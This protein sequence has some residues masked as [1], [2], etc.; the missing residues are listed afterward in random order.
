MTQTPTVGRIVHYR[1]TDQDVND[2]FTAVGSRAAVRA[3]DVRPAIVIVV[4]QHDRERVELQV[5]IGPCTLWRTSVNGGP[6]GATGSLNGRWF[7]PP[8]V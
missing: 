7:W 5:M 2:C 3:G 6:D 1:L 8:R 4:D